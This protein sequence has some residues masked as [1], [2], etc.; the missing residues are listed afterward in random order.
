MI[1]ILTAS[2]SIKL[3]KFYYR[4]IFTFQST[5]DIQAGIMKANVVYLLV[6]KLQLHVFWCEETQGEMMCKVSVC[7]I[8]KAD[9]G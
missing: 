6:N 3:T 8:Y 4:T 1:S 7:T 5:K 9:R 2:L